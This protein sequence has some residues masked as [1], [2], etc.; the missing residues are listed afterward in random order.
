MTFTIN[1]PKIDQPAAKTAPM[2][3]DRRLY[4]DKTKDVLVEEGSLEARWLLAPAG[5][6]IPG[7]EVDRLG[8]TFTDGR[9]TQPGAAEVPSSEPT[10]SEG[11]SSEPASDSSA[12]AASAAET[13]P[14]ETPSADASSTTPDGKGKKK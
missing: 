11:A 12:P 10:S 4:L 5:G 9:V 1:I 14:A 13:S 3:S 6:T 7:E 2:I 8:L